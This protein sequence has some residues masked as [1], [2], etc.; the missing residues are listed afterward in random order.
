MYRKLEFRKTRLFKYVLLPILNKKYHTKIWIKNTKI[1][2]RIQNWIIEFRRERLN[3]FNLSFLNK[4][5]RER[6]SISNDKVYITYMKWNK[7]YPSEC[8]FLTWYLKETTRSKPRYD[9]TN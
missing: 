2:I 1:Y 6:Y 7:G 3:I 5:E 9:K 4:A 8:K